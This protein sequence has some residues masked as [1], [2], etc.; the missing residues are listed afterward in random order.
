VGGVGAR[1]WVDLLVG[2]FITSVVTQVLN[3]LFGKSQI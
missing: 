1:M 3:M 2:R